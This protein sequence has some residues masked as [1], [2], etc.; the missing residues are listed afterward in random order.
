MCEVT[1]HGVLVG[2]Y[3]NSRG[4]RPADVSKA[5]THASA[6]GGETAICGRVKAGNLCDLVEPGPPTCQRCA[7]AINARRGG[8]GK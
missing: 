1:V 3:Q 8:G 7:A 4:R 2:A 5:L 6:D